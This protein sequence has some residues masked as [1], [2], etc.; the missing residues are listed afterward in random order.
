MKKVVVF[1][2]EREV[3]DAVHSILA[4]RS[5]LE[6]KIAATPAEIADRRGEQSI[7]LTNLP[8]GSLSLLDELRDD[9]QRALSSIIVLTSQKNEHLAV[10]ALRQGAISYVP[11]RLLDVELLKTIDTVSSALASRDN[12]LR[13]L[14][15][16]TCWRNEFVLENDSSLIGPLVRYL[17][18]S[19]Q[20]LGLLCEPG[21][22]TRMGIALE[23]SLLNSMYHGNL[24]VPSELREDDDSQFY[25]LVEKRRGES[26]YQDR[27]ITVRCAF[28]RDEA[29]FTIQDEGPGF[30]VSSIPDPTDPNNVERVS[31][32][33]M[34]LMRTFMDRVEYN[35]LGNQV[36][37]TKRRQG[38]DK[39]KS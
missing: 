1:I 27:R 11:V 10:E 28:T 39:A 5:D 3:S 15:C 30:D 33:G 21:E 38:C 25:D 35:E 19:T 31:G 7:V 29:I 20:R 12:R 37:L 18:E 9:T 8:D 23:E 32:R 13:I 36:T 16:L 34:L 24:E 22:D 17:Q 14:E 6:V 4:E 26:P 2:D